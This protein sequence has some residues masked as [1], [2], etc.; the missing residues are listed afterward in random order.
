M[1]RILL[2]HHEQR[3]GGGKEMHD[4][5]SERGQRK[6]IVQV[7]GKKTI[8]APVTMILSSN[9]TRAK[10]NAHISKPLHKT[11]PAPRGTGARW[12]FR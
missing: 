6:H 2:S 5:P 4:Q 12:I 1:Q 11:S 9:E 7:A 10:S 8:V 3:H